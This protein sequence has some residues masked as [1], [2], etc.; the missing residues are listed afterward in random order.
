M[1]VLNLERLVVHGDIYKARI[2]ELRSMFLAT[3]SILHNGEKGS[4][5]E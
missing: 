4:L 1:A 5:R 3:G 2:S